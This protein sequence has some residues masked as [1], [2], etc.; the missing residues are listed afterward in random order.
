MEEPLF[1]SNS[2][3]QPQ[4]AARAKRRII[5]TILA[6]LLI[7]LAC[8]ITLRVSK[9]PRQIPY[10]LG[11]EEYNA[12]AAAIAR[13]DVPEVLVVG[14]SR[15]R[16][17]VN[18]PLLKQLLS[19]RFGRDVS[20]G[21]F[22]TSGAHTSDV[23]AIVSAA[24]RAPHPPRTI[25]YG[26]AERDLNRTGGA[27]DQATRFWNVDDWRGVMRDVGT[28]KILPELATVVR[29]EVGKHVRLLGRR[30]QIRLLARQKLTKTFRDAR[31]TLIY[32]NLSD[33]QRSASRR[34]L[35]NRPA[36]ADRVRQNIRD[37]QRREYPDDN[38]IACL[39]R[40]LNHFSTGQ[41]EFVLFE[42]PPSRAVRR[43][44]PP[45]IYA[46]FLQTMND[47]LQ[48]AKHARFLT[49]NRLGVGLSDR[50]YREMAHLNLSGATKMTQ[51]LVDHVGP[52]TQP[53]K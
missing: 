46:S 49:I 51:A 19:E 24:L 15:A 21:S 42:V 28:G 25:L 13:G 7:L 18:L 35:Q 36:P 53:T 33:W 31:D 1:I 9:W 3:L 5:T 38:L 48:G 17:A 29:N 34:S 16:E 43:A 30:E 23:E 41:S 22:A 14:S 11:G 45:E 2:E 44:L 8:E 39:H 32:G 40:T 37:F 6:V 47:Q 4:E 52:T 10:E 26:I 12:V 50:D 27:F 20:V